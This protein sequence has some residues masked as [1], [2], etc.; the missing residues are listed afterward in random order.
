MSS[1]QARSVLGD[2][3]LFHLCDGP[4]STAALNDTGGF[5][6]GV[7]AE[8]LRAL[9]E[10]GLIKGDANIWTITDQGVAR[11]NAVAAKIAEAAMKAQP[12]D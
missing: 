5:R 4:M 8:A 7:A 3:F 9:N 10:R 6:E 11:V 1:E 12:S 2:V